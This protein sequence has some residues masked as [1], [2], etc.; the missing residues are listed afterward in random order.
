MCVP[1][2]SV[3]GKSGLE[4]GREQQFNSALSSFF[5]LKVYDDDGNNSRSLVSYY[6]GEIPE[7]V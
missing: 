3:L 6:L 7:V 1:I 2:L 5:C 4:R